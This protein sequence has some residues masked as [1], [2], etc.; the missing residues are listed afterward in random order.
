MRSQPDHPAEPSPHNGKGHPAWAG[1][2]KQVARLE[3]EIIQLRQAVFSHATVAQAIGVLMCLHQ[4]SPDDGFTVP[5]VASQLANTKLHT[6]AEDVIAWARRR[7]PLP[8]PVKE[9]LEE[10][11]RLR[12]CPSH[13]GC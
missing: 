10:A 9:A 1:C 2:D 4:L 3:K 12:P 8:V 11:L 13:P 6:V 5:R 7:Q